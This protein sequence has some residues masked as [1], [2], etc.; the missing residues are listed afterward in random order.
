MLLAFVLEFDS[1][2]GEMLKLFA[3]MQQKQEKDQL[4]WRAP[5]NSSVGGNN[6]TRVDEGLKCRIILAINVKTRTVVGRRGEG[7]LCDPESDL[8]LGESTTVGR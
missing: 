8:L 3:K 7:P 6:S 2:R 5:I 4:L 1:Q